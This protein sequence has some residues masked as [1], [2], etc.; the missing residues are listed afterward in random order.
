MMPMGLTQGLINWNSMVTQD[1]DGS[2]STIRITLEQAVADL[3]RL[4][5]AITS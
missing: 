3:E 2:L 4:Y 1:E 5:V